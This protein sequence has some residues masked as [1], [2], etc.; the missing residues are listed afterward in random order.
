VRQGAERPIIAQA[1]CT[2]SLLE[3]MTANATGTYDILE[4][5]AA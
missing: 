4:E 2:C 1:N 5:L 3:S